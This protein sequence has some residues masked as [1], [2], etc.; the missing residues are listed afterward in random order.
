MQI[1]SNTASAH[2]CTA[3]IDWMDEAHPYY[4]PTVNDAS[5]AAFVK[6]VGTRYGTCTSHA[7]GAGAGLLCHYCAHSV[8]SV[9]LVDLWKHSVLCMC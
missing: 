7:A 3:E 6:N 2:G 1:I 5:L 8:W 4:P 9:V